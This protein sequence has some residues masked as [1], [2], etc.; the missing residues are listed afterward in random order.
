MDKY[1]DKFR[2]QLHPQGATLVLPEANK[3]KGIA[4]IAEKCGIFPEK[5]I[6]VGDAMSDYNCLSLVS[7]PAC[8]ANAD[9]R[10]KELLQGKKGYV[11]KRRILEGSLD[12]LVNYAPIVDDTLKRAG[13][14]GLY[15]VVYDF[16]GCLFDKRETFID[17]N[18]EKYL[19]WFRD[20]V[21]SCEGP[22]SKLP[23]VTLNTGASVD[24]FWDYTK[25]WGF[26][27]F[28]AYGF[29]ADNIPK[30]YH[31]S[32]PPMMFE[33]GMVAYD[34]ISQERRLMVDEPAKIMKIKEL[35]EEFRNLLAPEL[36][37][38]EY[39]IPPKDASLSVDLLADS[40]DKE[41]LLKVF[42]KRMTVMFSMLG[43]RLDYEI[44]VLR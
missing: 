37:R 32:W 29:T 21:G 1:M 20:L 6:Y 34:P 35:T 18:Q 24:T 42:H 16:D 19:D 17:Q 14:A 31:D 43:K 39:R 10:I 25:N 3:T 15:A 5:L 44:E 11:S 38:K 36:E 7:Y 40:D 22:F 33:D 9:S 41:L 2:L 8:P 28:E 27:I 23:F 13:M 30:G 4:K 26:P 12:I